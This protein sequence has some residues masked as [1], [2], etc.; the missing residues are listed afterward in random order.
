MQTLDNGIEVPTNSDEYNL[1]EDQANAFKKVPGATLVTGEAQ[2]NG[3]E[4]WNGRS[5]QRLDLPGQPVDIWDESAGV[6]LPKAPLALSFTSTY[7]HVGSYFG[8]P[9]KAGGVSRSGRR[10]SAQGGLANNITVNYDALNP[11]DPNTEYVL[12]WFDPEYAPK[13]SSELFTLLVNAYTCNVRVTP[14][15]QIKI[16]FLVAVPPKGAGT[17]IFNLGGLAWNS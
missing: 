11:A 3:L 9:V 12:A 13:V 17:M 15:G 10:V 14:A 4:K 7:R 5:V 1:T 6:W 2:R 16:S 8:E